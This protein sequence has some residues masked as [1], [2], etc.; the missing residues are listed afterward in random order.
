[1]GYS[2]VSSL[3][4]LHPGSALTMLEDVL[5]DA[6]RGALIEGR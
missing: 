6:D 2:S 3:F 1:M 4:G 5:V